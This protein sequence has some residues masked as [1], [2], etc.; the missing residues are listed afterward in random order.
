MIYSKATEYALNALVYLAG[1]PEKRQ[2]GVNEIAD[3][4]NIPQHFLGKILQDLRKHEFVIST[5][6]RYGGFQLARSPEQIGVY[7]IVESLEEIQK[8]E[9]CI[10]DEFECTRDRPCAVVCDWNGVKSR[11][12]QFLK[13]HSIADLLEVQQFR[14]VNQL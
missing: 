4:L 5:R 3:A 12:S 8:Y 7:D 10:F 13:K 2:C 9:R 14:I 6:G 1:Q 11:I